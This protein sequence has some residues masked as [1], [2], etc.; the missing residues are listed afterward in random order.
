MIS[1]K[2]AFL[3]LAA[4]REQGRVGLN[5]FFPS[6]LVAAETAKGREGEGL[7]GVSLSL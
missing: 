7:F 4:I 2:T 1:F 5:G 3:Y 6:P